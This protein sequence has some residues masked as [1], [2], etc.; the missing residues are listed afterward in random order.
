M[1]L[2]M[3]IP[4]EIIHGCIKNKR[5]AQFKLY[6]LCYGFLMG[7]CFRYKN[8]KEDAEEM[9]NIG[10]MKILSHLKDYQ[11]NK[12]HIPFDMWI[13]RIMINTL[14]DDYRKNKRLSE[15]TDSV[16][17]SESTQN[18]GVGYNSADLEMDA[19][20]LLLLIQKLPKE[21]RKVF[22]LFAIDGFS[23]KEIA[24]MLNISV[25]TSKWHVSV[26]RS[27]LKEMIINKQNKVQTNVG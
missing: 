15:K 8:N 25:G 3:L 11:K 21:T 7:I 23:H 19:E 9:V 2:L 20:E 17:F 26:A 18:H 12:S 13:R 6:K 27:Q 24:E 22:N 10:F 1:K 16:D 4:E 14:I 5:K